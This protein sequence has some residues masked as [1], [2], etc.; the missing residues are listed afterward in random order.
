MLL[1]KAIYIHSITVNMSTRAIWG[2]YPVQRDFKMLTAG[3]GDQSTDQ[4]IGRCPFTPE[5]QLSKMVTVNLWIWAS[6]GVIVYHLFFNVCL[7]PYSQK[8]LQ[9]HRSWHNLYR[10]ICQGTSGNWTN[11]LFLDIPLSL[12]YTNT[13]CLC[14]CL[15]VSRVG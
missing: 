6:S 11:Y 9:F 5:L 10:N 15:F 1:S 12:S 8:N 14:V 3:A 4:P 7:I 2:Y 13:W